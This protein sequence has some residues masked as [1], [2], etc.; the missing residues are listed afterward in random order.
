MNMSESPFRNDL[1]LIQL[2]KPEKN[3][4]TDGGRQEQDVPGERPKRNACE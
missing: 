1:E 2:N 4:T 3:I